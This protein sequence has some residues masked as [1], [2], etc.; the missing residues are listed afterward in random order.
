M[1][2]PSHLIYTA[3]KPCIASHYTVDSIE[4][5]HKFQFYIKCI[6][7]VWIMA[8]QD[9]ENQAEACKGPRGRAT[10]YH[11]RFQVGSI[12]V[13]TENVNNSACKTGRCSHS[14]DLQNVPSESIPSSYDRVSVAAENVEGEGAESLC[15]TQ[16][17]SELNFLTL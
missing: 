5:S 12:D 11:I 6:Q 10:Q 7:C 14:F 15:T 1:P 16:P 3:G 13:H 9:P 17:I 8:F 2:P 4:L